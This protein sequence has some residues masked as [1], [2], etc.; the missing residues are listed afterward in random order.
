MLLNILKLGKVYRLPLNGYN[1]DKL[2]DIQNSMGH[3][4]KFIT[5]NRMKD[6]ALAP[7]SSA[8]ICRKNDY[9]N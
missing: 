8:V 3:C 7:L 2:L 4:F 6:L 1:I 5:G 9:A